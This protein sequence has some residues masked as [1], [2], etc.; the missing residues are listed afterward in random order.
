M[1]TRSLSTVAFSN[2]SSTALLCNRQHGIIPVVIALHRRSSNSGGSTV[3]P[4]I[5]AVDTSPVTFNST[6]PPRAPFPSNPRANHSLHVIY[7]PYISTA[8]PS[9]TIPIT[10]IYASP[11]TLTETVIVVLTKEGGGANGM[12]GRRGKTFTHSSNPP[13]SQPINQVQHSAPN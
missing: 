1:R 10:V 12:G 9:A 5:V 13:D 7:I 3:Q 11:K 4:S 2:G 6:S 8:R